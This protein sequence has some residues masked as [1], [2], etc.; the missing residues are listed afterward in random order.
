VPV[1]APAVMKMY[2]SLVYSG[3]NLLSD[4]GMGEWL[5]MEITE[6]LEFWIYGGKLIV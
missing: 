1:A 6:F 3:T 5:P 2:N 4:F